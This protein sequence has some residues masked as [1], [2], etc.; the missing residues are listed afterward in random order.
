MC[1]VQQFTIVN[2]SN[3]EEISSANDRR[4][5]NDNGST[6]AFAGA[7]LRTRLYAAALPAGQVALLNRTDYTDIPLSSRRTFS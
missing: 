4:I 5:F 2:S 7:V 1:G 3:S 6:E